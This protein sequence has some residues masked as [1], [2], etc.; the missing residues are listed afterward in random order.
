MIGIYFSGT[1]NSKYCI[2]KFLYEYDITT[3]AYSIEDIEL[4]KHISKH[5]DIVFSYPVQYSNIPK[6]LKDFIVNHKTMWKDKRV[7][8]IATMGLFSG[9]G[10]GVL[11]RELKK[12][13]ATIIGGLHLKMPDSIGDEKVLKRSLVNNRNLILKA[14]QKIKN[15]VKNIKDGKPQQEGIGILYHI[16]GLFGQRLYFINKTKQYSNKLNINT[17][18][19]IGCRKCI[20]LCPMRNIDLRN[21]VAVSGHKCTLCY[22][23]VNNCPKQ[24]ITLLGKHVVE[25]STIDKYL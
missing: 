11:A 10:A 9:D 2:E 20:D 24:A 6:I 8:V 1:G 18:K 17:E 16:A 19:C 13:G 4:F 23:C 14:E 5:K 3:T 15:A 7:F 21:N 25:Q 22:R 12:Y